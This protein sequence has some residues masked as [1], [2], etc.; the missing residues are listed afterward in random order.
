MFRNLITRS[1]LLTSQSQQLFISPCYC[2]FRHISQ[3][4]T[5]FAPPTNQEEDETLGKGDKIIKVRLRGTRLDAILKAGL[6]IARSKIEK[7]FY[8]DRIRVNGV[9]AKKKSQVLDEGDEVDIVR[10]PNQ[11]N[12]LFIDVNRVEIVEVGETKDKN[13]DD[14]ESDSDDEGQT[15]IPMTLKRYKNLTIENYPVPWKGNVQEN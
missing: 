1:V 8:E 4:R 14:F 11:S 12:P 15:K 10:G 9:R 6:N 3:S 2:Q 13:E 5:N 7:S